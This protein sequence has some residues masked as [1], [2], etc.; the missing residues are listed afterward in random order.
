MDKKSK[1]QK[2]NYTSELELKS[3]LI[4]VKNKKSNSPITDEKYNSKINKYIIWHT[5]I[6]NKKYQYPQRRNKIKAKLKA[7]IIELSEKTAIDSRSYE[8]FGAI[9]LLMIKNILKKPNFS[10][11]TYRDD[12]YSDSVHKILK[13]L[14]NF[15]HTMISEKSGQPVNS[16]A[17]ISQYIHNSFV[18]IINTKKKENHNIMKQVAIESLNY[19]LQIK[20]E[21]QYNQSSFE[22]LKNEIT[23]T[24][25]LNNI[26]TTLVDEILKLQDDFEKF[27]RVE[28]IY[29][30]S[31]LISL[32]EYDKLKPLLKGKINIVRE[33]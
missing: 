27:T 7:K 6:N 33:R 16:F 18:Y 11:Y 8:Q 1:K 3:L 29:P 32:D 25:K 12:F 24:I 17:Y 15:D 5:K 20:N 28:I 31:Y 19:N 14:H 9:I 13:Y 10:G 4:R 26:K 22:V 21:E 30:K 2:H 23:E